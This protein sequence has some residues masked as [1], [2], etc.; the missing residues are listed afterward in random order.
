MEPLK[1]HIYDLVDSKS[2]DLFIKTTKAIT[3]YVRCTY[4]HGGDAHL[5]VE[6]LSYPNLMALTEPSRTTVPTLQ[7]RSDLNKL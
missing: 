3:V 1:G 7:T 4:D 6:N 2:A 5:M